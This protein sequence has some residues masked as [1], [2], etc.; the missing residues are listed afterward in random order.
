MIAADLTDEDDARLQVTSQE[1]EC[2]AR[3]IVDALGL[4][5]LTELGLD[6]EAATAPDVHEPPLTATEGDRVFAELDECLDFRA[7]SIDT[8]AEG[9]PEDQARCVADRYLDSGLLQESILRPERDPAFNEQVDALV[10]D[11]TSTCRA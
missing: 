1:A 10:A 8:F 4:H 7:R 2:M 9:M 11:A 3:G 5:R 6:A